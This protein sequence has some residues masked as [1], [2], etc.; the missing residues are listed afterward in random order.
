MANPFPF[1][2]GSVLTAAE[3]NGIGEWTDYTPTWTNLTVGNAVQDFRYI[4]VNKFISVVGVI[5]LGSTSS[6]TG[7]LSFTLPETAVTYASANERFGVGIFEDQGTDAYDSWVLYGSTTTARLRV[8]V[9]S[10]TYINSAA[11][12][13]NVPFIWTTNDR[14]SVNFIYEA[15]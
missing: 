9:A 14:I 11:V 2:A 5:T 12:A 13:S 15:A 1:V 6:V 4:K 8:P 3:L 7:T 10:G